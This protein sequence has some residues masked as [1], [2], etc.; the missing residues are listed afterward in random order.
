MPVKFSCLLHKKTRKPIKIAVLT[1]KGVLTDV[2]GFATK[3]GLREATDVEPGEQVVTITLSDR[4]W[5]RH[6][7][8]KVKK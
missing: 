3:K 5:A 1:D 2:V 4:Q 8:K 6:L 7:P